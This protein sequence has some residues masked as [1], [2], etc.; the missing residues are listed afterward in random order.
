MR[1]TCLALIGGRWLHADLLVPLA[2]SPVVFLILQLPGCQEAVPH[3]VLKSECL[4]F[5]I[6]LPSLCCCCSFQ[7]ASKLYLVLDFINGGHLFFNLYR[8][9]RIGL[10]RSYCCMVQDVPEQHVHSQRGSGG[11]GG[12]I[13]LAWCGRQRVPCMCIVSHAGQQSRVMFPLAFGF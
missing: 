4:P 6:Y 8:Q 2:V 1:A 9:V 3:V 10:H 5:N 12:G 13:T 7:T 11:G